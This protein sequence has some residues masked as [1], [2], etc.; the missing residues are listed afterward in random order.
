[1]AESQGGPVKLHALA[2]VLRLPVG[3]LKSEARAGRIPCLRVGRDL[4]FD[5][6]AVRAALAERARS[7]AESDRGIATWTRALE[8][9]RHSGDVSR[10]IEA[11][12]ELHQRGVSLRFHRDLAHPRE[13][14]P[15]PHILA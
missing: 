15:V 5:V 6:E 8:S 9:A 7:K 3:W 1:M 12:R 10:E 2:N 11:V 13:T 4:L 14:W